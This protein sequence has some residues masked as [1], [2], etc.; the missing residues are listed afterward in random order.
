MKA[1]GITQENGNRGLIKRSKFGRAFRYVA[2]TLAIVCT[3]GLAG[4]FGPPTERDA[5]GGGAIGAGSG[6][7]I[8]SA[9]GSPGTGAIIGGLAGA[10]AGYLY[11]NHQENE[12]RYY[13]G[14]Y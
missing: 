14:G 6:A 4:C 12:W 2:G 5:I 11:G 9:V 3:L 1:Q 7:L 10:G 8:G 13:H